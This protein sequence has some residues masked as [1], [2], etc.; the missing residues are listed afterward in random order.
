MARIDESKTENPKLKAENPKLKTENQKLHI[1]A[2]NRGINGQ[3]PLSLLLD[4]D[5]S[6]ALAELH[7]S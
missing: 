6:H 4:H 2:A 1:F 3:E 5:D 7:T